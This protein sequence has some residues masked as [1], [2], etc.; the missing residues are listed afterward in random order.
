MN[1]QN[2]GSWHVRVSNNGGGSRNGGPSLQ[3]Q[4]D[5]AGAAVDAGRCADAIA[6]FT[7]LEPRIKAGSSVAGVVALRK[8]RCLAALHRDEAEAAL[9]TGLTTAGDAPFYANDRAMGLIARGNIAYDRFDYPAAARDYAA[10]RDLLPVNDRFD[11]LV[12]LAR[13]TM[14]EPGDAARDEAGAALAIAATAKVKRATVAQL[15]TLHARALLS[16]GDLQGGYAELRKALA[17]QG[18]LTTRVNVA[19]IQTRFDLATPALLNHDEEEARKYSAFTGAGH[20]TPFGLAADMDPPPCDGDLRRDDR[21]IVEFGIADSGA[22]AYAV[23][24]YVSHLGTAAAFARAVSSWSW[25]HE[26]LAKIAPLFR[27]VTRVELR[28]STA[29]APPSVIAILERSTGRWLGS[30]GVAPFVSGDSAAATLAAARLELARRRATRND[31][32]LIRSLPRSAAIP[33]PH[34]PNGAPRSSMRRRSRRGLGP[35][36][37]REPFSGLRRYEWSLPTTITGRIQPG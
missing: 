4:F 10:G 23:P 26:A 6:A 16:H 7:A 24:V 15:R 14:F 34:L 28:C 32:G 36:S 13:A 20:G 30:R 9:T 8:G 27:A 21:A 2:R 11:A 33:L 31:I 18:G 25:K 29:S 17:E 19:D 37:R 5:T 12:A 3:A 1:G 35:R 22:V